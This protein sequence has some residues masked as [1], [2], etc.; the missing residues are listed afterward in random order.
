MAT[1]NAIR[2]L[3]F[4]YFL[5]ADTPVGCILDLF[6]AFYIHFHVISGMKAL[7]TNRAAMFFDIQVVLLRLAGLNQPVL[8]IRLE[9]WPHGTLNCNCLAFFLRLV[10]LGVY[11]VFK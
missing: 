6:L 1:S 5:N 3:I 2:N 4:I 10:I 7:S 11:T 8:G 9:L